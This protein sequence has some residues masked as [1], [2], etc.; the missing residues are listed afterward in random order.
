[1]RI[2]RGANSVAALDL[3][4][5]L[6]RTRLRIRDRVNGTISGRNGC[7]KRAERHITL[8][9]WQRDQSQTNDQR[10][11]DSPAQDNRPEAVVGSFS[12]LSA[13]GTRYSDADLARLFQ[14]LAAGDALVRVI[15]QQ[16]RA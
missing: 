15:D 7:V 5:G 10:S 14:G 3:L 2:F 12:I 8:N 16:Q 1:M 13:R 4:A 6:Q 9:Q 11:R